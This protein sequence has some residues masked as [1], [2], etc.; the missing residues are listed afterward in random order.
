VQSVHSCF[1]LF[2]NSTANYYSFQKEREQSIAVDQWLRRHIGMYNLEFDT[3]SVN[4]VIQKLNMRASK[5]HWLEPLVNRV[6]YKLNM[7][8]SFTRAEVQTN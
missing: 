5:L 7:S 4:R 6:S 1:N 2:L 8:T 3:D